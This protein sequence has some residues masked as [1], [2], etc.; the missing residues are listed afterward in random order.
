MEQQNVNSTTNIIDEHFKTI[1]RFLSDALRNADFKEII[2]SEGRIVFVNTAKGMREIRIP[3]KNANI[4]MWKQAWLDVFSYYL[5]ALDAKV[6]SLFVKCHYIK[7]VGKNQVK[8]GN[9]PIIQIPTDYNSVDYARALENIIIYN[10]RFQKEMVAKASSTKEAPIIVKSTSVQIDNPEKAMAQAGLDFTPGLQSAKLGANSLSTSNPVV[11]TLASSVSMSNGQAK[12]VKPLV[13]D[14][15]RVQAQRIP[16]PT[17]I[18]ELPKTEVEEA[19]ETMTI[20]KIPADLSLDK[21]DCAELS[22]QQVIVTCTGVKHGD[23]LFRDNVDMLK[24]YATNVQIESFV[25]GRATT[26]E[27]AVKEATKMIKMLNDCQIDNLVI[28]EINNDFILEHKQK[29]E[30]VQECLM[31]AEKIC[32]A[33]MSENYRPVMCC[34]LVVDELI[35]NTFPDYKAKYPVIKCATVKQ[36]DLIDGDDIVYLNPSSDMDLVMINTTGLQEYCTY[37]EVVEQQVGA[38]SVAA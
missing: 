1:S 13:N 15:H 7:E 2:R 32:D 30:A 10:N 14:K 20:S 27:Q 35:R 11:S 28:Y 21:T 12:E 33:L 26:L 4:L 9:Y 36:K 19:S 24:E 23:G 38:L 3:E 5:D 22:D 6:G 31:A 8:V 34:D 37:S 29:P 16:M 25:S 18:N 17:K